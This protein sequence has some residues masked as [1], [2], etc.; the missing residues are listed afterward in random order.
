V[1]AHT[2]DRNLFQEMV[3]E[4]HSAFRS[5]SLSV[6]WGA[7]S[8]LSQAAF[9]RGDFHEAARWLSGDIAPLIT[10][11]WAWFAPAHLISATRVA[12]AAG[13]AGLRTRVLQGVDIFEREQPAPRLFTAIVQHVRGLL[14][15]DADALV[16]AAAELSTL[17]PL[18]CGCAAEDAG[19]ELTRVGRRADAIDQFNAAFDIY[20][21]HDAHADA[22]RV[23]RALRQLGVERRTVKQ[24]R[25]KSGW[26]SLTD[27][28]LKVVGLV[29]EGA[30]NANVAERLQLSPHTVKTHIRNA[31][32]KLDIHSRVQLTDV[33]DNSG[34]PSPDEIPQQ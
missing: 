10:P 8:V 9:D 32:A 21:D 27:A 2:G 26:G 13:D 31:F 18:H 4:A 6:A 19:G 23:A 33:M 25:P 34:R 12:A 24:S 28:E 7:A 29:A 1:A 3:N 30:T 22:R 17:Q 5:D 14:E 11:L 15:R 20:A 16:A